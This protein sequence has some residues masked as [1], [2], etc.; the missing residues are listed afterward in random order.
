MPLRPSWASKLILHDGGGLGLSAPLPSPKEEARLLLELV[1]NGD[2]VES[3]RE[4]IDVPQEVKA[5]LR[6]FAEAYPEEHDG[7]EKV[8]RFR[9]RVG[10]E[11]E[12]LVTRQGQAVTLSKPQDKAAVEVPE[13]ERV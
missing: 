3:I 9:E 6:A 2:T 10:E 11:F 7:V 13:L 4:L 12:K 8:L 1:G 5:I